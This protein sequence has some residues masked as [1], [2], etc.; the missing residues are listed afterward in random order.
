MP[1]KILDFLIRL[2][3]IKD[4]TSDSTLKIYLDGP[5]GRNFPDMSAEHFLTHFSSDI[6]CRIFCRTWDNVEHTL[7]NMP[8][9][10]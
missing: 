1:D 8:Q 7:N 6:G 5:G 2:S 10:I 4:I 9:F 3:G